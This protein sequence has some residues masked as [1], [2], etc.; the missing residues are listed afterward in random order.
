MIAKE[1]K[2]FHIYHFKIRSGR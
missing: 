2:W 1:K